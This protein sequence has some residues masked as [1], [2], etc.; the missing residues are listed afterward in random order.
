MD[1]QQQFINTYIELLTSTFNDAM[2]KNIVLQAQKK[3]V[4][5]DA[6]ELIKKI[7][8][9]EEQRNSEKNTQSEVEKKADEKIKQIELLHTSKF[10]TLQNE[11]NQV[12]TQLTTLQ[13][14]NYDLKKNGQLV[15]TYK[16]ELLGARTLIAK[17]QETINDL[18]NKI[19]VLNTPATTKK[20]KKTPVVEKPSLETIADTQDSKTK[21]AGNF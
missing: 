17:L 11:S 6:K 18:Q 8:E 2:Q 13:R 4:E 10:N 9:L 16:N 21:D 19:I 20:T 7:Q 3:L 15:D 5:D 12:K 1:Q 14:E